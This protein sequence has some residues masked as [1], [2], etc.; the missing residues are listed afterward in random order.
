MN[1]IIVYEFDEGNENNNN[2]MKT[3]MRCFVYF[4][5]R[6]MH[7]SECE[8]FYKYS[9]TYIFGNKLIL[10]FSKIVKF[11]VVTKFINIIVIYKYYWTLGNTF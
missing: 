11:V 10:N 2:I 5:H 3:I 1:Q 7:Y 6:F 9:D 8:L 4:K